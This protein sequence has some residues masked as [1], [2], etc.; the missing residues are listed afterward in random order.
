MSVVPRARFVFQTCSR[1]TRRGDAVKVSYVV[2]TS[3]DAWQQPLLVAYLCGPCRK[4]LYDHLLPL[5]K[6]QE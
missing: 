6:E 5:F 1:C 3:G 4:W 2:R